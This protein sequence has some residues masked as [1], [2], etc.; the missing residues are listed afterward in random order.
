MDAKRSGELQERTRANR[1]ADWKEMMIF[2]R[3]STRRTCYPVKAVEDPRPQPPPYLEDDVE[4]A[5][6]YC[7]TGC[8]IPYGECHCRCGQKTTLADQTRPRHGHIKGE[9]MRFL[10]GHQFVKVTEPEDAIPFKID[11]VYCRLIPLTRGLHAIVWEE[12]YYRL[13]LKKWHAFYALTSDS[14]YAQRDVRQENGRYKHLPMGNAILG[15]PIGRIVD[16]ANGISLDCRRSNLRPAT[17]QENVINVARTGEHNKTGR[18]GVYQT[19]KNR[20]L[21]KACGK[22]LGCFKT[23]DEAGDV[24]DAYVQLH[25]GKFLRRG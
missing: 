13:A 8:I 11:G 20:Y 9:P 1:S 12:D 21:A 19:S 4:R 6:I 5:C 17:R 23:I 3:C 7:G 14:Y 15:L 10:S 18:V 25:W 2:S 24:R 22:Y 16:H